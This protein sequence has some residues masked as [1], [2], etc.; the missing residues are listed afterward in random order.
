[1]TYA[2]AQNERLVGQKRPQIRFKSK[3]R[4]QLDIICEAIRE[5]HG[6]VALAAKRLDTDAGNL[7]RYIRAHAMAQA[8]VLAARNAMGDFAESKL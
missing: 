2:T 6:L 7:R 8:A 5:A 1:M 4:R 3:P